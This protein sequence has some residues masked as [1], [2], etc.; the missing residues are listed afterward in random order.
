MNQFKFTQN[1]P[2]P[3]IPF[4]D[5]L[6]FSYHINSIEFPARHSHADYWEFTIV[7]EG[8][9]NNYT[10]KE[11]ILY[12]SGSVLISTT[13]H[14]HFILNASKEPLRYINLIVKEAYITK[15][16]ETIAPD[17][18][19]EILEGN[20]QFLLTRN[21]INEIESILLNVRLWDPEKIA[22][23][24]ALLCSAFL[25]LLSSL[26]T[27]ATSY[28]SKTGSWVEHLNKIIRENDYLKLT[29]NEL[30]AKLG[31]SRTQLNF[32]F[33]KYFGTTPHDYLMHLKFEHANYLL[34]S[35]DSTISDISEKLGYANPAA[36][37]TAFKK[38]YGMTPCE[39]KKQLLS[40]AKEFHHRK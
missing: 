32:L 11:K 15:A 25:L 20:S 8:A 18:L 28:S 14:S 33:K 30:C 6:N 37:Y 24:E 40:S 36:F 31:Y 35:S 27:S 17:V 12:P 5:S 2:I 4:A 22:K 13:K 34:F 26:I 3:L 21:I 29:T 39:Y 7:L 23:N 19:A 16:F 9:M 1:I 10:K 38:A